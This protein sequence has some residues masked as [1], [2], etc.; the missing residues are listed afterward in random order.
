MALGEPPKDENESHV[1]SFVFS[2]PDPLPLRV[3]L[4]LW[5]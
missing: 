5:R 4:V 1:P 3:F 2:G